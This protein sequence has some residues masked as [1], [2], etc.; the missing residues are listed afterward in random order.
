MK[1]HV[2]AQTHALTGQKQMSQVANQW[3]LAKTL[4]KGVNIQLPSM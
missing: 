2:H 1:V 3:Q 4:K